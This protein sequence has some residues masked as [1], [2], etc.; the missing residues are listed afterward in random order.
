MRLQTHQELNQNEIMVNV[1]Y[2][3]SKL[4]EGHAVG[5]EQKIR[6]LNKNLRKFKCIKKTQK[7]TLKP[8]EALKKVMVNMNIQPTAKYGVTSEEV[9]KKSLNS[10]KFSLKYNFKRI[11]DKSAARYRMVYKV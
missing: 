6:E 9:E 11:N 1:E 7:S 3:N 2:F 8:S 5:A 4:N 10:E